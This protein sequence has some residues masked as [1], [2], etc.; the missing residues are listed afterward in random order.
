MKKMLVYQIDDLVRNDVDKD[1]ANYDLIY[2]Y[3]L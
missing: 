1:N 3:K 2:Q